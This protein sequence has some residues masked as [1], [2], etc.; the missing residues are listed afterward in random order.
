MQARGSWQPRSSSRAAPLAVPRKILP[1]AIENA[2]AI[3]YDEFAGQVVAYL[4]SEYRD[5]Y[6]S[7]EVWGR[8]QD[9]V[10]RALEALPT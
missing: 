2:M 5:H 9:E 1:A 7:R 3:G 10:V 6:R 4:E 8:L